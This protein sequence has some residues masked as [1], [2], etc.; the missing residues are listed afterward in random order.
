MNKKIRPGDCS[1]ILSCNFGGYNRFAIVGLWHHIML[2][3]G[4]IIAL[5]VRLESSVVNILKAK[6]QMI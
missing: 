3:L 2:E 6:H 5:R 4:C 1:S